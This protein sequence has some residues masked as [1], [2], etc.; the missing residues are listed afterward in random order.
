MVQVPCG[1]QRLYHSR[2][3]RDLNR[4]GTFPL[5]KGTKRQVIT[6]RLLATR[7]F[8]TTR[9]GA[10]ALRPSLRSIR[11]ARDGVNASCKQGGTVGRLF[12]LTPDNQG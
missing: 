2:V 12:R 4:D 1:T 11:A 10:W 7:G 8:P 5:Q 9:A 3:A 6:F